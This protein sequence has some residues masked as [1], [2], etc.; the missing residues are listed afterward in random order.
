M[1]ERREI[2]KI[3]PDQTRKGSERN[4]GDQRLQDATP[5]PR[6]AIERNGRENRWT[7]SSLFAAWRRL[8]MVGNG[9]GK[10]NKGRMSMR[11][12]KN[13]GNR[14]AGGWPFSTMRV[15]VPLLAVAIISGGAQ[16]AG[17]SVLHSH[18]P[19][20]Q[21]PGGGPVQDAL[22]NLYGTTA[23]GGTWNGG[24]VFR[25]KA[26]GAD[27]EMLHV[28]A[29]GATDGM[30]PYAPLILD[31]SGNLYGTTSSGGTGNLGT[32]FALKTDGTGFQVLHSFTGGASDGSTPYASLILDGSGNLY[33]TTQSGGA[34]GGG[35]VFSVKTD[36]A[37]YQVLHSF[38][39]G[40]S[41]GS[42]PHASLIL[43]GFGYLYGTTSGGGSAGQGTEFKLESLC[44]APPSRATSRF[45]LRRS[46]KGRRA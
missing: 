38:A 39:G 3:S 2:R 11:A 15:L 32:I 13:P 21:I 43:D 27:F 22:G 35:T 41:D 30:R 17:I 45:R 12:T 10:V 23:Y 19:G 26:D 6:T 29:G 40:A 46:V 33:G 44:M 31:G 25:V 37:S 5:P 28:F 20:P 1:R 18:V 34:S 8:M 7:E 9:A 42:N 16:A 24:T 14:A 36:G 4:R